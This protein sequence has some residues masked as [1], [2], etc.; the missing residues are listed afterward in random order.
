MVYHV[1]LLQ[2]LWLTRTLL[3][4]GTFGVCSLPPC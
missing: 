3:T 4:V 2:E 1:S